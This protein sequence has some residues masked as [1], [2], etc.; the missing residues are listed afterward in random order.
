MQL[1]SDPFSENKSRTHIAYSEFEWFAPLQIIHNPLIR[2]ELY[3]YVQ[4][5]L[6]S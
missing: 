1:V 3:T 2:C 6:T 5:H 4:L